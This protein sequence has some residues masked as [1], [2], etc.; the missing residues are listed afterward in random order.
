MVYKEY[1]EIT[2]DGMTITVKAK[3]GLKESV[4]FDYVIIEDTNSHSK[5]YVPVTVTVQNTTHEHDYKIPYYNDDT[6]MDY[7]NWMCSICGDVTTS[8]S[9]HCDY[10][11]VTDCEKHECLVC[12]R[13]AKEAT[14]H[15]YTMMDNDPSKLRS[16][17]QNCQELDTYLH[18][19]TSSEYTTN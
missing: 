8:G 13:V 7:H 6:V 9:E 18:S 3:T 10:G 5:I 1:F 16:K 12:G 11:Y 15:D 19:K 14:G 2:V 17:A 4:Y